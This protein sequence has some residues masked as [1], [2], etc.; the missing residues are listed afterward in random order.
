METP[1]F[2]QVVLYI[3]ICTLFL[4]SI[5]IFFTT[6]LI[7]KTAKE[8]NFFLKKELESKKVEQKQLEEKNLFLENYNLSLFNKLIEI[9]KQLFLIKKIILEECYNK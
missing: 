5:K 7:L 1:V 2:F 6:K 9:T 8:K 4:I 3:L